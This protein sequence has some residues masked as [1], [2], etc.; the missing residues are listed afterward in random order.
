[1]P[2]LT[3][4][5]PHGARRALETLRLPHFATYLGSNFVQFLCAQVLTMCLQWLVT[6]LTPSRTI[7][8]L[9]GFAQGGSVA[10][11]SPV[12]GVLADRVRKRRL[13][14]IGRLA[15]ALLAAG[16]ALLVAAERIA[17]AHVL[18]AASCGGLIAALLQ[19]ATQTYV[20]DLVGR[21]RVENAVA[22][23]AT[24]SGVAQVAGPALAGALIATLGIAG[25]FG[26]AS[27]GMLGAAALL[28]LVPVAGAPAAGLDRRSPLQELRAGFA[29]V[30]VNPPVRLVLLACSMAIFNG[31]H[32][33][34]RPVFARHVLEVGSTGYGTLAA[35][36]GVGTVLAALVLATRRP[37]GRTGFWVVGSMFGYALGIVAYALA[38]GFE[39]MLLAE[40][41][42][43]ITGQVWNV[44]AI[45]GLQLAVPEAMRGRILG[46]VFM[47][48]QLGFVGQLAVG[49]LA[50]RVGDRTALLVFGLIPTA[51]L[52]S[53][54]VFGRRRLAEVR[55]H[56]HEPA[57]S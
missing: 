45:S 19:P 32:F 37:L 57:S 25:G 21:R 4:D 1:L 41:A 35:A 28:L 40:L 12:A 7:L 51:V 27:A 52:G 47:L 6:G 14:V 22:L 3:D 50:D 33:A 53:I 44:T 9:V 36:Q 17:I 34:M 31:A 15:I 29:W 23:N 56:V 11:A 16:L 38:P 48:A 54:L 20:F 10:L 18:L 49:A 42:L 46:M 8:G 55:P 24:G 5:A 43:G 39:L 26:F 30:R 2:P 13:L